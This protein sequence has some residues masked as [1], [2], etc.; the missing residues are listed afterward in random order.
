MKAI[1]QVAASEQPEDLGLGGTTVR[2]LK[3]GR[4]PRAGYT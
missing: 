4:P 3:P 1:G 2:L